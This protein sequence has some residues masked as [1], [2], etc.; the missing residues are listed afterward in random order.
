MD[1]TETH[2]NRS[3]IEIRSVSMYW[4]TYRNKGHKEEPRKTDCGIG[5]KIWASVRSPHHNYKSVDCNSLGSHIESSQCSCFK[6]L[7]HTSVASA[8]PAKPN[9]TTIPV[10]NM[11]GLRTAMCREP[12]DLPSA[13]QNSPV[14]TFPSWIHLIYITV[15]SA[16]I[17]SN[18][19]RENYIFVLC[20]WFEYRKSGCPP[21]IHPSGAESMFH[22][23]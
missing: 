10:K 7:R 20:C 18:E 5:N 22:Y 9:C 15:P 3:I 11:S 14:Y 2:A 1:N 8:D 4:H 23:G 6:M 16:A 17:R 19:K 13:V 12:S 21:Y